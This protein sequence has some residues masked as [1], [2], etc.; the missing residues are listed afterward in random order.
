P[1]MAC[2]KENFYPFDVVSKPLLVVSCC[3]NLKTKI[4]TIHIV[5]KNETTETTETTGFSPHMR[6]SGFFI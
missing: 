4:I 2:Q 3:L 1:P 5:N 6:R